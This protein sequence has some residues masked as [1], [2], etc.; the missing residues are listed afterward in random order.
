M[1]FDQSD[2][3]NQN[4]PI[5]FYTDAAKTTQLTTGYTYVGTAGQAGAYAELD[6][7][8]DA[9]YTAGTFIYYQCVNHGG[10]GGTGY[11]Q[12]ITA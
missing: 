7:S 5:A 11:I 9:S 4:H 3:S 8:A 10:M 6:L 12:I 2:S 1:Q